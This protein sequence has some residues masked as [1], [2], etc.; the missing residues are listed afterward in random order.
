M[1][2]DF[3]LVEGPYDSHEIISI[4]DPLLVSVSNLCRMRLPQ[5]Q[6]PIRG[7]CYE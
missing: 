3:R 2:I 6:T 5:T 1:I 7:F 4:Q